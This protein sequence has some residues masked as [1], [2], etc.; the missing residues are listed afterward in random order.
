MN[1]TTLDD[2]T[3]NL[4]SDSN[5]RKNVSE[6]LTSLESWKLRCPEN[7]NVYGVWGDNDLLFPVEQIAAE[8][9]KLSTLAE[10]TVT[11]PGG[12]HFHPIERPWSIADEINKILLKP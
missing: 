11:I 3:K 7:T 5:Y 1:R 6:Y 12:A 8:R 4:L 10:Q 2:L 9:M